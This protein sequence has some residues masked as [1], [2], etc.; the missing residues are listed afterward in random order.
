MKIFSNYM[1]CNE[2]MLNY[3]SNYFDLAFVDPPYGIGSSNDKRF[4]KKSSKKATT[5]SKNYCKKN[6]DDKSPSKEY[7]NELFRV[8]KNQIVWGVN[9]FTDIRLIGGRIFWDKAIPKNYNKSKGE[10]AYKSKNYG[11]G[12]DYVKIPW[13]GWLQ[14]D[15]KNKEQRIHPTQ[16]PVDLYIW[17]LKKYAEKGFKIIDTH[18]GSGSLTIACLEL[19]YMDL[20]LTWFENDK[21]HYQDAVNRI[22]K[23]KKKK[24]LQLFKTGIYYEN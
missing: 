3:P 11:I 2:G 22:E 10:L 17:G 13:H 23:Y 14:K 19:E 6:W 8:S 4:G 18:H 16:K 24:N 12:V 20:E 15:M 21:D 5:I 1:D 9:Y 7:W